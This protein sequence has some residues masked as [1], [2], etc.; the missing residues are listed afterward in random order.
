MPYSDGEKVCYPSGPRTFLRIE[1]KYQYLKYHFHKQLQKYQ[2][3][4]SWCRMLFYF[5]LYIHIYYCIFTVYTHTLPLTM[6]KHH[7]CAT[8]GFLIPFCLVKYL[9][10]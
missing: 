6:E 2:P 8:N 10:K 3:L 1:V 9:F 5:Y 7:L 4:S